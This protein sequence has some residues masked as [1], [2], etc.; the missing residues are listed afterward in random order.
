MTQE[1]QT[2]LTPLKNALNKVQSGEPDGVD[3]VAA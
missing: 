2:R 1:N 3:L